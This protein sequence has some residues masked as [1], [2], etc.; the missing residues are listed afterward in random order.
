MK[1]YQMPAAYE[2]IER[3]ADTC[4][5]DVQR[6]FELSLFTV[7][8][9]GEIDWQ[10]INAMFDL[11]GM[12][13]RARLADLEPKLEQ[14]ARLAR[15]ARRNARLDELEAQLRAQGWRDGV[16][17]TGRVTFLPPEVRP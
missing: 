15:I 7:L 13:K 2:E 9:D 5:R 8:T 14:A 11:G 4:D 10:G 3:I 17:A 6:R 12:L 1:E 16:D